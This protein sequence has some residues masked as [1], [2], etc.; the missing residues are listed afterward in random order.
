MYVIVKQH[1]MLKKVE[2]KHNRTPLKCKF[3]DVCLIQVTE[4][5]V[6]HIILKI[7][8]VCMY[9]KPLCNDILIFILNERLCTPFSQNA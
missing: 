6:S 5:V 7:T 4:V 3:L 1:Y 9:V 2:N 8:Y